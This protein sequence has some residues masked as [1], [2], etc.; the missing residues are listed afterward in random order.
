MSGDQ[1]EAAGGE[2]LGD[3]RRQAVALRYETDDVAPRVIAKGYGDIADA[4]ISRAREHG[5]Q[6]HAEPELV[7]LL[8][9]VDLDAHIPPSL[10]VAVAELLA[11]VYELEQAAVASREKTRY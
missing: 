7:R 9:Q 6:V 8:A 4:I 1:G 2:A 11:W 10:Y 5:L 3:I